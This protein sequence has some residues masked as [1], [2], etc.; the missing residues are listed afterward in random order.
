MSLYFHKRTLH[1]AQLQG[2]PGTDPPKEL[3]FWPVKFIE[4]CQTFAREENLEEVRVP[5]ADTLYSYRSPTLNPAASSEEREQALERIRKTMELLYDANARTLG[6]VLDGDSF[7][8][9][10]TTSVARLTESARNP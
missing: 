4:A 7:K 10:N 3:R 8:W 1:I 6:F 5:R 2:V 9:E